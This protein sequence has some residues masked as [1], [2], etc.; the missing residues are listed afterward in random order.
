VLGPDHPNTLTS[1]YNLARDLQALGQYEQAREL[2]MD[3]L[4]RCQH[5][6]A[7]GVADGVS[8][9]DKLLRIRQLEQWIR[10]QYEPVKG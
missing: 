7:E 8:M 10:S 6:L 3:I 1:A 4:N 5:L 2:S 9:P